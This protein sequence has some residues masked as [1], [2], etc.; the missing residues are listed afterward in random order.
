[1]QLKEL[2]I[3]ICENIFMK[4]T[5]GKICYEIRMDLHYFGKLDQDPHIVKCRIWIRI[6]VKSRIRIGIKVA[7]SHRCDEEQD[8]DLDPDQTQSQK[9]DPDAHQSEK[10][11][12]C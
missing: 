6:K 11:D 8:P 12:P 3:T 9:L 7:D 1:M 5:A 2:N 10:R 4:S